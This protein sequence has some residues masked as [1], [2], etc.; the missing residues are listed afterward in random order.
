ML[1]RAVDASATGPVGDHEW[2]RDTSE[3]LIATQNTLTGRWRG[4]GQGE[5]DPA[6]ATSFVLLSLLGVNPPAPAQPEP[7]K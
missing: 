4:A 2:L 1:R 7:A 3:Y 6:I 5:D